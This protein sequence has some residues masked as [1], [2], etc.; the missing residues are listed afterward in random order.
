MKVILLQDVKGV[1]KK[2]QIIEASDG[3]VR[4]FLMPK[5]LAVEASKVN[6]TALETKKRGAEKQRVKDLE[7]ARA[8]KAL[9]ES[10]TITIAQKTGEGGRLFGSVTNKEVAQALSD[11]EG[12]D[13]DR[14]KITIPDVIKKTGEH[15]VDVRLHTDVAAK[16][17]LM[18][19]S[20]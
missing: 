6:V 17:Q 12:I 1:G 7:D 20:L 3:Y 16:L 19:K 14:K 5:K 10:K 15:S 2:D 11:Q 4:N 9:L 8:M 18:I 13:I